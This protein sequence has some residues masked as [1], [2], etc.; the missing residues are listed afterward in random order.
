MFIREKVLSCGEYVEVDL[1]PRTVD[2]ERAVRGVR[3]KKKKLSRP[4][5][6]KVNH[7]N[8]ARSITQLANG[9]FK[10]YEDYWLTLTYQPK[11]LPATLDEAEKEIKRYLERLSYRCRKINK[12]LKY[13]LVTE[14]ELDEE[15]NQVKNFH[16][17]LIVNGVLD[18]EEIEGCWS[19]GRGKNKEMI[20][21]A[22]CRRLQFD[23]NGIA[24]IANYVMKPRFGK[25]GKKKW[26]SSRN[27]KRPLLVANDYKYTPK[28][29]EKMALSNDYGEE[30]LARIY[31]NYDIAEVQP[32]YYEDTGWHFYLRMWKKKRKAE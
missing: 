10:N 19:K 1:I 12:E 30:R 2:A 13:I 8:S 16:H 29:I 22:N 5:Q 21:R 17:H 11:F 3:A 15:G 27:L 23:N 26:S 7:K 20:G 4:A 14:Y 18:R 24:G 25:R 9:N 28:Q 31:K 32:I 6:D